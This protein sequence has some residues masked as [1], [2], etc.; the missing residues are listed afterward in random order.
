MKKNLLYL[1]M[2]FI[3][4]SFSQENKTPS[5]EKSKI[6]RKDDAVKE[7]SKN[8]NEARAFQPT[9]IIRC[10]STE[11]N[12]SLQKSKLAPSDEEFERW[13][14]PKVAEIKNKR[15]LRALPTT[16]VIPVVIHIVHNGDAVGS[17]ENISLAQALSQI[18]VFNEDF[19]KL[20]GTPG[21]GA[22]VDTSIQFCLAQ[23]DPNGVATNGVVRHN[24]GLASFDSAG[25][26]SAK[27]STI[28][29]PTKYLNMWTF[30]FGGDLAGVLGYAQFPTGSGLP[31][32][33][34]GE[35]YDDSGSG[36]ST[37]G[38]VCAYT[39]WGSSSY[40]T[41]AFGAPYDKGRTMTHEVGHMF[42]LR[43]I[44]GD[45]ACPTSGGNVYTNEDFCADTPAASAA[46]F[47]C[48]AG[49][50]TCTAI[51]GNDQIQNYMDYTDDTCMNI[52]TQ[53]QKDRMLA[54]LMNSPR[55]DDLLV[56]TVCSSPVLTPYIQFKRQDCDFRPVN[57]VQ[58]GSTCA[59]YTEF[60]IVLDIDKAP[61]AN[62]TVTF[63]VDGTSVANAS[64]VQILTPTVTFP[65]GSTADQNLVIRV[66]HD[67]VVEIDEDLV[68]SFTV[69]ANG[70][71][72]VIN[73]NGKTFTVKILNDDS[74]PILVQNYNAI[75][76]DCADLSDWQ[77]LDADGDAKKWGTFT[78][79]QGFGTA[80][81]TLTNTWAF[82]EK[83]VGYF[84]GTISTANPNNYLISKQIKIPVG[85]T[86]ISLSYIVGAYDD[87]GPA[88]NAG[89]FSVYFTT[90]IANEAAILAGTLIQA[91]L[92]IND[93]TT[94]LNTHN[95][96]T[97]P[98]LMGQT[99]YLVFRH[100]NT[101]ATN[102]GLL[103]L[104]SIKIA[105]LKNT[106]V[107]TEINTPTRYDASLNYSGSMYGYDDITDNVIGS[108]TNNT[109]VNYGCTSIEVNRSQTSVGAGSA[110]FI[111]TNAANRIMPKT[112]YITN[113][114][115]SA[116]G[117]YTVT[118][119]C[120]AAEVTAWETATGKSRTA[121]Q[122]IKVIN[123]PISTIN[124]SNYT[125]Y[126]IEEKAATI[127]AF[128]SNVTFTATFNTN[129]SGGYAIGPKTG[130]V[131]G[132]LT[133][134]WNG[135]A[136]SNGAPSKVTAV[137]FTGNYSSTADLD[138]CSATINT[139]VNVTFN[140]G[141]TFII[142]NG[143][144]VNGTGTF[145]INNNAA[146]R[147]VNN[148]ANTGNVIVRRNS[149]AN[150]RLDYTAWSSPVSG[151]QLQAFSPS[152]LPNRFYQYLFTGTT[153]P[154]AYQ[155][156][157]PTTNFVVGKGYMIRAADN[158]PLTPTVFNGQFAGVP[159]NGNVSQPI[160]IGYNLLGNPYAS[161]ISANLF[162]GA[163]ASIPTLYFWTHTAPAS[164]G[165]YPVNNYASYTTLGGTAAAAGGAV[166]NGTI[167]TSQG[168]FVRATAAGNANFTNAQ[169]V[170]ASVS[171]Q[172][173]R[174][175][176]SVATT[177]ETEKHRIWL[178][179]N[180][181]SNNYNQILVGYI[182]GATNGIDHAIDGEVLDK[183]NTMLYNLIADS[184]YVIQGKGLPFTDTDEIALGL[185]ATT[186]GTYSI[187]LENVD[188][189]FT[190]Q[191]VYVKDNVTNTIHD[192]KLAPYTFTTSDG[193]YNNR[194]KV[195][196]TN[197]ALANPSFVSD[198]SV[199][200][201]TQNEE[202]KIN[203]S[204][205]MAKVEVFDV[206][207]RNIYKNNTVNDKALNIASIANRNQA[208]FV[209]ITFATGQS[210]TKKVIK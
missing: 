154:T 95:L 188:G 40:A 92:V 89:S 62:A 121:L 152:T 3:T 198:E 145:T 38:V 84:G 151:Q 187:A 15:H 197:A 81:N 16:I 149:A 11:H 66:L 169:R 180:D 200:V 181:A 194:F 90:S 42:G 161:P 37:D 114:T 5:Q 130:I 147:Q 137:T 135:T 20:A 77:N 26:E 76:E 53:D 30:N 1:C 39:T 60:T 7:F 143:V 29:D 17:G 94:Q 199:V 88:R 36:A 72:A 13:L 178:N 12:R 50:N 122:I 106:L 148:T 43:H 132:D 44:W 75:D 107:Q 99:G 100:N 195:V 71:N 65:S 138:A 104:D 108:I 83:K 117:N 112:Y 176:E 167:Q 131:C 111:D 125:N 165:I 185:K 201:F 189:L 109:T 179:L 160:G 142:G 116:T 126:T 119:Y 49:R 31:G 186:A 14:A 164:G 168:F 69:N 28:W 63:A 190:A 118:L 207:G 155:V 27:A 52:F 133:S 85:A 86:S 136:W 103:I 166:P 82:S 163:N 19:G 46:N 78:G 105:V 209:K 128:G 68:I 45:D 182:N 87:A 204:Q 79:L 32:M 8:L 64:D 172:F 91:N 35:C 192:I 56:S 150:V 141:H 124:A 25:V 57:E 67:G 34:G 129:M 175:A 203:A 120:T 4:Y 54:V 110:S 196:F 9:G 153:T 58:E 183:D 193:V 96:M 191:N 156:V 173:Y 123:N 157:T 41:G 101:S 174:T 134:T 115:D 206:L 93:G 170:N 6:V 70:G 113:A 162:L 24:L 139:G 127:G 208:L 10:A 48:P 140:P 33:P 210:V 177:T 73:P 51:A 47:G 98:N 18:R 102:I 144:T 2:F 80:P 202:L 205:E 158:W 23:V 22:G 184:E 146:L 61:S 74:S 21:D 55:R 59:G 171:T 97:T 159:T